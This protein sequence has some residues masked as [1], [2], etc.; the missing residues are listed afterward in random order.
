MD[1]EHIEL[2]NIWNSE[3]A[4]NYPH[5][6]LIKYCLR[7]WP[8]R[9]ARG[10]IKVLD[11]GCGNGINSWFLAREGFQVTA[12]DISVQGINAT[13]QR[14]LGDGLSATLRVESA[15]VIDELPESFDLV[16]CVGV[17]E[18]VGIKVA[19]RIIKSVH[20]ILRSGGEAFFLFAGDLSYN[21]GDKTPY[22]LHG[23]SEKEVQSLGKDFSGVL[24][25]KSISTFDGQ[26]T[27]HFEWKMLM[28]K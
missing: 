10:A 21:L 1:T 13:R 22:N 17:L 24:I 11:L 23:Y 15:D 20:Q 25:D 7:R 16:I 8:Q 18:V 28:E 9:E 2:W 19:Q 5:N 3:K 26:K 14:L 6:Q 27:M 4:P 12:T